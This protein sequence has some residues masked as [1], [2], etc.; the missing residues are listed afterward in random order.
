MD[1]IDVEYKG[2]IYTVCG[3]EPKTGD[4][5]LTDKYGVWEFHEITAPMPY[6]CNP[7]TC[8]KIMKKNGKDFGKDKEIQ[9]T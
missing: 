5:V 1:T 6:W 3:D 9:T 7:K 4:M 2:D 8:M